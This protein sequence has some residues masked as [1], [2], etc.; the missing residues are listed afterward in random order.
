LRGGR[1]NGL[2]FRRQHPIGDYILDFYCP[3]A[4]LAVEV[5]GAAHDSPAQAQR[6]LRRQSW[7]N[8]RGIRVL[9]F[10]AADVL[11]DETLDGVLQTIAAAAS[12]PGWLGDVGAD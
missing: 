7:L 2:R 8:E 5:D 9:R 12:D 1:L 6:D 4:R 3:S 11:K 10:L